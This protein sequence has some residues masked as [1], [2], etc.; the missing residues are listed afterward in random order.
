MVHKYS[1]P[2]NEVSRLQRH[3][4]I[5]TRIYDISNKLFVTQNP[6]S[7]GENL[8][9]PES[10][11][12]PQKFRKPK[13]VADIYKQ[14]P[15]LTTQ[16]VVTETERFREPYR[17][18]LI[19]GHRPDWGLDVHRQGPPGP[20]GPPGA[21]GPGGPGGPGGPDGPAGQGPGGGP[22]PGQDQPGPGGKEV[23]GPEELPRG[24]KN[25]GGGGKK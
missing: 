6:A 4:N 9:Y 23:G 12:V 24:G 8:Y 13:N 10:Y 3:P 18:G 20:A 25:I 1:I 17:E 11:G 15:V 7:A 21:D 2:P 16:A 14:Q 22:G 5:N 19:K